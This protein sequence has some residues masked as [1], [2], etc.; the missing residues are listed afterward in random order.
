MKM[1]E[2]PVGK[3]TSYILKYSNLSEKEQSKLQDT[4][5]GF[6][7]IKFQYNGNDL[8]VLPIRQNNR[9]FFSNGSFQGTYFSEEINLAKKM[10]YYI[11]YLEIYDYEKKKPVL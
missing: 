10:G 8:P 9:L 11:E 1:C 2:F 6:A 4:F 3:P 5:F 7:K